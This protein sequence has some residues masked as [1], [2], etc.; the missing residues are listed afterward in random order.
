MSIKCYLENCKIEIS[1]DSDNF[2]FCSAE[3]HKI[4]AEAN[5]GR[6]NKDGKI[7]LPLSEIQKRLLQMGRETRNNNDIVSQ[8][9]KIFNINGTT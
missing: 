6:K 3:H 9:E 7:K 8:A 5:Y 4:W 2:P 1:E